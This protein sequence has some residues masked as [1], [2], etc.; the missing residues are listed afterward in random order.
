MYADDFSTNS[1]FV[2]PDLT[3][4]QIFI[5]IA[6][7]WETRRKVCSRHFSSESLVKN[8]IEPIACIPRCPSRLESILRDVRAWSEKNVPRKWSRRASA[9]P[10]KWLILPFFF[11]IY[12][13]LSYLARVK[14]GW[15]LASRENGILTRDINTLYPACSLESASLKHSNSSSHLFKR[16]YRKL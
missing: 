6:Q 8:H 10:L 5:V 3:W 9:F 15:K 4:K 13:R 14:T 2:E 16:Y 12:L 7:P 1:R 11:Y